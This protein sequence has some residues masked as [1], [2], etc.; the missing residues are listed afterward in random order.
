MPLPRVKHLC[1][2]RC[3]TK[4][5]EPCLMPATSGSGFVRC[6][7][8]GGFTFKAMKHGH[9]TIRAREQRKRERQ[10]IRQMKAINKEIE[11]SDG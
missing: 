4:G 9:E 3:R 8:H 11:E 2:A 1:G 6:R 5:G 7:I 10:L